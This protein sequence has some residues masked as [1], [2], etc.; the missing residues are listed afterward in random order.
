LYRRV[1]LRI[2]AA[3]GPD[4]WTQGLF[5]LEFLWEVARRESNW[6]LAGQLAQAMLERAPDYPGS[7]YCL[8][9]VAQHNKDFESAIREF[10]VAQRLWS[11]ADPNLPELDTLQHA[12]VARNN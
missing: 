10:T 6:E 1:V 5:Q 8:A 9:I 12:L 2:R 4:A 3:N 11:K 7:H